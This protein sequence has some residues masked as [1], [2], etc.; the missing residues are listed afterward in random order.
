MIRHFVHLRFD[1]G[2]TEANKQAHYDQLAGL[3][4]HI[5]GVLDFQCRTTVS[6]KIPLVHGINGMFWFDFTDET[7]RDAYLEDSVHQAAGAQIVAKLEGG[8]D[9]VFVCDVEV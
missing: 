5:D 8:A 3:S 7:V 6:V 9:G 1:K 2:T 4:G